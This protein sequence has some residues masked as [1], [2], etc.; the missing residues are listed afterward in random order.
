[1]SAIDRAFIRAYEPDGEPPASA[2]V[3]VA[4]ERA[5]ASRS[6][7]QTSSAQRSAAA[8]PHFRMVAEPAL[9]ARSAA[10]ER[11][12]LSTFAPSTPAVDGRFRPALEVDRFRW[13][14]VAQSLTTRHRAQWAPL[15]QTV[16]A[17]DAAGRS[18]IGVVGAARGAGCT[19][20]VGCLAF[21]FAEAGKTVAVVD[22]DFATAGLARSL[23]LSV[24]VG[25]EDVLA[26]RSP[27]AESVI[28]SL[29]DRIALLPLVKG[30]SAAA[31]Q[32]DGIHAS[33]TAG[34]LRYHYDIVLFDLGAATDQRQCD[35][36]CRIARRCRL[37]A[38]LLIAAPGTSAALADARLAE[39][40]P[41]LASLVLGVIEN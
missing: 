34:V 31:E 4:A 35:A 15:V 7:A 26:G 1:M 2:P 39:A 13:P 41:E 38:V 30:G 37:D 28:H 16:L 3:S 23:G 36:A 22:G 32:I 11:R 25:W 24:D 21:L 18:L 12:P 20:A 33:V 10:G 8:G 6:A 5:P 14:T 17:A 19:T 9:G 29:D 27:L 40:A